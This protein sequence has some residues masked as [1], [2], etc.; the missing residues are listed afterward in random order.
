M[1]SSLLLLLIL[2]PSASEGSDFLAPNV[3][4]NT[5]ETKSCSQ[6][7]KDAESTIVSLGFNHRLDT[8]ADT[9]A[10]DSSHGADN[11]QERSRASRVAVEK[12][13]DGD[14]VGTHES[15]VVGGDD[16]NIYDRRV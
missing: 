3:Y 9:E 2:G 6:S 7:G 4:S 10:H 11:D 1:Q 14:D 5:H 16:P 12:V 13:G 8:I 15:E